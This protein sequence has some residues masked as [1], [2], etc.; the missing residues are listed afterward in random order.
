MQ[1][2]VLRA[3][4]G[5]AIEFAAKR[6]DGLRAD[7]RIE[8]RQVHEVVHVN[9]QRR[10][11]ELLPHGAKTFDIVGVRHARTP[12]PGARREDLKCIRAESVRGKRGIFKRLCARGVDA[13][14]Q[15][16]IV[17]KSVIL[18][19]ESEMSQMEPRPFSKRLATNLITLIAVVLAGGFLAAALVRYSPGFDSI[20]E[21]LNPQINAATLRAL[22]ERHERA[23]SLPV[24]YA[25]YLSGA[26]QGDLGVSQNLNRPVAELLR[27]R[28]PDQGR[29]G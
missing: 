2:K 6:D 17:A 26:M 20:P 1:H 21:D 24:F 10:E 8:R 9:D 25:R 28:A 12:H 4:G 11:I 23:N 16:V 13:D 3:D 22:H 15:T 19:R 14:S 29:C 27:W 5:R 18:N 7:L